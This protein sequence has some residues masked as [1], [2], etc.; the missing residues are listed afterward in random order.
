M[1]EKF[2]EMKNEDKT[3]VAELRRDLKSLKVQN[4]NLNKSVEDINNKNTALVAKLTKSENEKERFEA[5]LKEALSG[6]YL[7]NFLLYILCF[8]FNVIFNLFGYKDQLSKHPET[9]AKSDFDVVSLV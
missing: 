1:I 8:V 9:S 5:A 6:I 4:N 2:Q 3:L 7:F